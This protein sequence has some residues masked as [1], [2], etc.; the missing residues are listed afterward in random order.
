MAQ[1]GR[2]DYKAPCQAAAADIEH[3]LLSKAIPDD[4]RA[5]LDA[6]VKAL[7]G[8]MH[9]QLSMEG[10]LLV[11]QAKGLDTSRVL[12]LHC[13]VLPSG[14]RGPLLVLTTATEEQLQGRSLA[15]LA[16]L[17]F[18]RGRVRGGHYDNAYL[19]SL[20]LVRYPTGDRPG[21]LKAYLALTPGVRR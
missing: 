9:E 18:T 15:H 13:E 19:P 16:V 2:I 10:M 21:S 11:S 17:V 20:L 4:D 12:F 8:N 7:R 5:D 1:A 14:E 6:D 3:R